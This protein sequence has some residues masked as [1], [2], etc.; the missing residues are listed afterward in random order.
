MATAKKMAVVVAEV[1]GARFRT[2]A[3]RNG[4]NRL[5]EMRLD[6]KTNA[7]FI[8]RLWF[9]TTQML[10]SKLGRKVVKEMVAEYG[11]R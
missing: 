5:C 2:Q 8:V 7:F 10:L 6:E 3:D 4:I 9:A 1:R 11:M